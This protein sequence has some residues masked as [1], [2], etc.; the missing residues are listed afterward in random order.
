MW[1]GFTNEESSH[2]SHCLC[3]ARG[4]GRGVSDRA[5]RTRCKDTCRIEGAYGNDF[6][7]WQ[8]TELARV[9]LLDPP[10]SHHCNDPKSSFTIT[11]KAAVAQWC[12]WSVENAGWA[13][14]VLKPGVYA[15]DG[16]HFTIASNGAVE[17][18]A[19]GF[20]NLKWTPAETDPDPEN[21]EFPAEILSFS[22]PR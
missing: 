18:T 14:E 5:R 13:W 21:P 9:S 12:S 3:A 11:S 17:L 15:T 4:A 8:L 2:L 6:N 19:S 10:A 7:G 1:G 20:G 16:I 22:R